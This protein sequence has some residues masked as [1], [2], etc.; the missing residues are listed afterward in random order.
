MSKKKKFKQEQPEQSSEAQPSTS[1]TQQFA[2]VEQ[3][4]EKSFVTEEPKEEL[5]HLQDAARRLVINYKEHWYPS[6]EKF[7]MSHGMD[8]NSPVW[9]HKEILRAWGAQIQE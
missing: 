7:A 5:L 1:D 4:E 6:I 8:L 9:R 3:P 2:A